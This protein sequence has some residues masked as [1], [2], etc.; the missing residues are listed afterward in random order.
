[1]D[2]TK[3]EDIIEW[4]ASMNVPGVHSF[5]ILG[6]YYRQFVEGF[7]KIANPITELQKKKNKFEWIEKCMEAFG[8]LKELLMT[9]SI[10]KVPYMDED[11]LICTNTSKEGLVKV[12]MQDS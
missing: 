12:L 5:M 8:R 3:V 2:T 6:G 1:L 10:L 7:S 11:F 9:T 4:H